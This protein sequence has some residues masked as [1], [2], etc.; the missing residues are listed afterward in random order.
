M[1]LAGHLISLGPPY[2]LRGPLADPSQS[3]TNRA[4]VLADQ[5]LFES[6]VT[7][8]W[9][10]ARKFHYVGIDSTALV[11][12]FLG[13]G[14]ETRDYLG[15]RRL[16]DIFVLNF[17]KEAFGGHFSF[18]RLATLA[19]LSDSSFLRRGCLFRI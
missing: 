9:K 14:F 15:S 17:R 13:P 12:D 6:M 4:G 3:S 10:G 18:Q 1:R 7:S 16:R 8:S 19:D 11:V 5:S 2:L